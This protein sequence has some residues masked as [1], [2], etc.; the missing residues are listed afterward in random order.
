MKR[1][2]T[3]LLLLPAFVFGQTATQQKDMSTYPS[4]TA[5]SSYINSI[6]VFAN[7]NGTYYN[8]KLYDLIKS[9]A[10]VTHT[11]TI[12]NVTGLQTALNG[13]MATPTGTTGQYLRGD[14]STATLSSSAVIDFQTATR[15][16]ISAQAG[17]GI[18]YN[19]STGQIGYS[20]SSS[21]GGTGPIFYYFIENYGA[22]PNDNNDDT[23]AVN[24]AFQ[25]AYET[26][27]TVPGSTN[28]VSAY[29]SGEYDF[30][31]TIN[32]GDPHALSTINFITLQGK[33]YDANNSR[34]HGITFKS[35][36]PNVPLYAVHT[37]RKARIE[38]VTFIGLNVITQDGGFGSDNPANYV[39]SSLL[40][41][42]PNADS[43]DLP[44][45][46]LIVDEFVGDG[47][48]QSYDGIAHTAAASSGVTVRNCNFQYFVVDIGVQ[49]A[50]RGDANGDFT[51]V[52]YCDFRNSKYPLSCGN[53]QSREFNSLYNQFDACYI[54]L[55]DNVHGKQQGRFNMQIGG[56][57]SCH[58]WFSFGDMARTEVFKA[59]GVYLESSNILGTAGSSTG[60]G[61]LVL[62]ACP[63][64][65]SHQQS[66]LLP[67]WIFKGGSI[68]IEN[69]KITSSDFVF[70][71]T[72]APT[73]RNVTFVTIR[74]GLNNAFAHTFSRDFNTIPDSLKTVWNNYY[75]RNP[76]MVYPA[77]SA[78][79]INCKTAFGDV[80]W[81]YGKKTIGIGSDQFDLP[82]QIGTSGAIGDYW[83]R[84]KS[85]AITALHNVTLDSTLLR[86]STSGAYWN[87]FYT[88]SYMKPSDVIFIS[89]GA[90]MAE[91]MIIRRGIR[92]GTTGLV[93]QTA[94]LTGTDIDAILVSGFSFNGSNAN[95]YQYLFNKANLLADGGEVFWLSSNHHYT[96]PLV[97]SA[98]SGNNVLTSIAWGKT[99][100]DNASQPGGPTG[101]FKVGDILYAVPTVNGALSVPS[102]AV[103]TLRVMS[104]NST[105]SIT[106]DASLN[107]SSSNVLLYSIYPFK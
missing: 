24:L 36:N 7:K 88:P 22:V 91:F 32:H 9:K 71:C 89:H 79:I 107:F 40:A 85:N 6:T 92:N 3:I 90:D 74:D 76:V 19:S 51:Q 86:F 31:S 80:Q 49:T 68:T 27:M 25:A 69:C 62:D 46:A 37:Q 35:R 39:N 93:N 53:S 102:G 17:S 72:E 95:F 50:G 16:A 23:H 55:S 84:S 100:D 13:K 47:V 96:R 78:N 10:D 70:N 60:G 44:Y 105:S 38:G 57:V 101:Q 4:D 99:A 97:A 73:F 28:T 67:Q 1:I 34:M 8:Y 82:G 30:D 41:A 58:Q 104:I 29:Q 77:F 83:W 52:E 11:H 33:P 18:T 64:N 43:R 94:D 63:I 14:G 5:T 21:G 75:E 54:A 103:Q 12:A 61:Q 20:G 65:L 15:M 26:S 2:L 59:M 45:I 56:Q 81:R 87:D 42:N 106:V 66:T 48:T 98:T